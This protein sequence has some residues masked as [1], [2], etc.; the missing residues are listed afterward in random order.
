MFFEVLEDLSVALSSPLVCLLFPSASWSYSGLWHEFGIHWA[1][2]CW[3]NPFCLVL[4]FDKC[5][6]DE[7]GAFGTCSQRKE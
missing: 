5:D 3:G 7:S 2:P 4:V 1:Q 6:C